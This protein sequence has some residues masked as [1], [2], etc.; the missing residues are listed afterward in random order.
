MTAGLTRARICDQKV[1]KSLAERSHCT[2]DF[3]AQRSVGGLKTDGLAASS[4][5]HD[6][7]HERIRGHGFDHVLCR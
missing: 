5:P 3:R 7:G 2:W 6:G 1:G 4:P